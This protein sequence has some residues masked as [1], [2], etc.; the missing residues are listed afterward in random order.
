VHK[1]ERDCRGQEIL[2]VG[3]IKTSR[4]DNTLSHM[5]R[6]YILLQS[7]AFKGRED[8]VLANSN[9]TTLSLQ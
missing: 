2:A 7:F 4:Y 1:N 8:I 6:M 3:H 5:T 9:I